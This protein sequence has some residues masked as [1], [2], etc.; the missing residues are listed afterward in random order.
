MTDEPTRVTS[1]SATLL[2]LIITNELRHVLE[3]SVVPQVIANHDLIV[4][5]INL[6]KLKRERLVKLFV[7]SAVITKTSCVIYFYQSP[8][9]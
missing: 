7:I 8:T 3:E 2:D 9:V 1:T 6:R 5:K 4:I